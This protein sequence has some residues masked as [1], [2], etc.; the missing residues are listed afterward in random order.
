MSII[1]LTTDLGTKDHYLA[2]LKAAI[3][4]QS[5]EVKII[6]ITHEIN[7]F[8]ILQAG[9]TVKNC[10]KDFPK[11]TIH[12]IAIDDELSIENDHVAV[13]AHG[14]YFI[15]RNLYNIKPIFPCLEF[16]FNLERIADKLDFIKING[17]QN[18]SFVAFKASSRIMNRHPCN[19]FHIF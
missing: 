10:F 13:Y 11:N 16:H 5:E 6:D 19:K 3:Y 14:H 17:F 8:N 7:H 1:T 2:S 9:L 4:S 18:N 12:I 15:A